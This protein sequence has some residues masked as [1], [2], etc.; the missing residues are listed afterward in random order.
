MV[1]TMMEEE[2]V[3]VVFKTKQRRMEGRKEN[4]KVKTMLAIMMMIAT[5]GWK[6]G[7]DDCVLNKAGKG[8]G[9]KS[10]LDQPPG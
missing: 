3:A 6:E 7:G 1:L 4:K 10:L 9:I 2:E 5:M 8:I